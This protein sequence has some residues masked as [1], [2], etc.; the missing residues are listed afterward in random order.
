MTMTTPLLFVG[1]TTRS[2]SADAPGIHVYRFDDETGTATLVHAENGID[3]PNWVAVSPAGDRLY[4]A[5]E[6]TDWNEGTLS[7]YWLDREAGKLGYMKK[8]PTLGSTTCHAGVSPDGRW[9]VTSNYSVMSTEERPD[10]AIAVF[11]TSDNGLEAPRGYRHSGTGPN[12]ERQERSHA[13]CALFTSNNEFFVADLG[14]DRL[15]AYRIED[16]GDLTAT[17]DRDV[18]FDGGR[19]PRHIV[20]HPHR[21]ILYVVHELRAGVSIIDLADG[22][23]R[24]RSTIDSHFSAAV[25]PSA[26]VVSP[27]GKHLYYCARFVGEI[28][29]FAIGDDGWLNEIGRWPTT[30]KVPRDARISPSG[31]WLLVA[32]Q[33]ADS[34]TAYHRD[35]ANGILTQAGHPVHVPTPMCV[36]F[37]G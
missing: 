16:N 19:G 2:V 27:D 7:A 13:H 24:L 1:S 31:N 34:V 32:D 8:Q 23:W 28:V 10:Q 14:L 25:S 15:V 12:A 17:P 37:L 20:K 3:N 30:G 29:G 6:V 11:A 22:Q 26:I 4:A 33:D 9:V 36:A 21:D 35:Q 18:V 5:S